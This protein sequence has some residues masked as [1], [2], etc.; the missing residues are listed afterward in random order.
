MKILTDAYNHKKNVYFNVHSVL[1]KRTF[2]IDLMMNTI[3]TTTNFEEYDIL[4]IS[5]KYSTLKSIYSSIARRL[6]FGCYFLNATADNFT[7]II[8]N[9]KKPIFVFSDGVKVFQE[10]MEKLN[11]DVKLVL[12]IS[13]DK[14]Q[15]DD[16]E[17]Y[18]RFKILDKLKKRSNNKM[19]FLTKD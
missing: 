10:E 3:I 1:G 14:E 13:H 11:S 16:V 19:L 7:E 5:S 15:N 6:P 18:K 8:T 4:L 9:N 17:D 2:F 12:C